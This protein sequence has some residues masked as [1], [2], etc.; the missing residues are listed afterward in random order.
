MHLGRKKATL[1]PICMLNA[2]R[3][4][5]TC[6]VCRTQLTK[7]RNFDD[8]DEDE[9]GLEYSYLFDLVSDTVP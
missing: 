1:T 2:M 3:V 6:P 9:D 5:N 4:K 7:K 8:E